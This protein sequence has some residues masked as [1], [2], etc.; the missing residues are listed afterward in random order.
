MAE[1]KRGKIIVFE[2]TDGSGKDTQSKRLVERLQ[3]EGFPCEVMSFP[4]Y[5]SPTGRVIG[6][7]Y[8]GKPD[9]GEGDVGWFGDPSKLPP[10]IASL[11]YAADRMAAVPEIREIT[12]SGKH[13]IFDRW[14][15]SNMAHQGGKLP[16]QARKG[17][18]KFIE[19]LEYKTLKLPRP[20]QI[21]FL[22]MPSQVATQLREKRGEPAD[23]HESSIEHLIRA[24]ETYLYLAEQYGWVK[25]DC[26]PKKTCDSL[27]SEDDIAEEVYGHV[28]KIIKPSKLKS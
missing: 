18:I 3:N 14:V 11:Y 21:I 9:L 6:Q 17:F 25:I 8:L 2:G 1:R 10:K 15:E 12:H 26:A 22:Y 24:E 7:A 13:L 20:N 27:K 23:G 5:H 28:I 4:R 19:K 16:L